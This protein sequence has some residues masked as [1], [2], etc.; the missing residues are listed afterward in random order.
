MKISQKS[1][2]KDILIFQDLAVAVYMHISQY[3]RDTGRR[4][5]KFSVMQVGLGL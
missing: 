2:T 3:H 4:H 5:M 1:N